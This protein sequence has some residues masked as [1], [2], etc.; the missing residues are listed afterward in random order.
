MMLDVKREQLVKVYG[1]LSAKLL[2]GMVLK[3]KSLLLCRMDY[4]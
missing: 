2:F 3:I 4:L 1:L